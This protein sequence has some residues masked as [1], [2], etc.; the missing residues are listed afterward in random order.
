VHDSRLRQQGEYA[1]GQR[2]NRDS[3]GTGPRSM[4]RQSDAHRSITLALA[5][6]RSNPTNGRD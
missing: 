5:G 1:R 6:A 2:R 4:G 3:E